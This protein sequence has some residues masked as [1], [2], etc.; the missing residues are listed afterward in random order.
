MPIRD[1]AD[2]AYID[3]MAT[4]IGRV[5]NWQDV[6]LVPN[7]WLGTYCRKAPLRKLKGTLARPDWIPTPGAHRYTQVFKYLK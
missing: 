6:V 5:K 1:F 2:S 3:L 4:V 7:L